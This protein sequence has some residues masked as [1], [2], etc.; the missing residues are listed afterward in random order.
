EPV[1]AGLEV[2]ELALEDG[3]DVARDV[4][5]H[6]RVLQRSGPALA[7]LLGCGV[8]RGRLHRRLLLRVRR[9]RRLRWHAARLRKIAKLLPVFGLFRRRLEEV[10]AQAGGRPLRS[11]TVPSSG[12]SGRPPSA[13][14][15]SPPAMLWAAHPA[16]A[17]GSAAVPER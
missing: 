5:V 8:D 9:R 13:H 16:S 4:L 11:A 3:D 14:A 10:G 15:S 17:T 12:S 2:L 1:G 7:V 6:L